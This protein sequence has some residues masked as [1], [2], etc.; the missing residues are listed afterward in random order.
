VSRVKSIDTSSI[1]DHLTIMRTAELFVIGGSQA[2]RLPADFRFEGDQ[3]YVWRDEHTGDVI[4]SSRPGP[5]WANFIALR[6]GEKRLAAYAM[7]RPVLPSSSR[8][9]FEGWV[10]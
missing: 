3:V 4:L 6:A 5:R 9:P 10:E 8:D 2:V 1:D 7:P